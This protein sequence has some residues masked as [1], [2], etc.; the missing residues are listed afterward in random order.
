MIGGLAVGKFIGLQ[1]VMEADMSRFAHDV[2]WLKVTPTL[3]V[4]SVSASVS[5]T[6]VG[7]GHGLFKATGKG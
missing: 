5:D 4:V 2:E 1:Y 6:L 3:Q 7:F